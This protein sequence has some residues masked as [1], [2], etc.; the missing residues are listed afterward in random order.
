LFS[1]LYRFLIKLYCKYFFYKVQRFSTGSFDLGNFEGE[2]G[3]GCGR[4]GT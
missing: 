1:E 4:G 2:Y 3:D